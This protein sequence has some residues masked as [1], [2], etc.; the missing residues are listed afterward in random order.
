MDKDDD[1]PWVPRVVVGEKENFCCPLCGSKKYQESVK[2]SGVYGPGGSS[3]TEFYFCAG[4]GLMF[5]KTP[6]EFT[7]A[8]KA[9]NKKGGK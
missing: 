5:K 9:K 2:S 4:C 1:R 7:R 3:W 6:A 8:I